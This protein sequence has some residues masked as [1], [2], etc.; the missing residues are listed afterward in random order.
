MFVSYFGFRSITILK[1]KVI[2]I[3]LS[4]IKIALSFLYFSTKKIR[5]I[6]PLFDIEKS[7]LFYVWTSI[8]NQAKYNQ[9]PRTSDRPNVRPNFYCANRPKWQ[10]F[11][12]QNTELFPILCFSFSEMASFGILIMACENLITFL[13]PKDPAP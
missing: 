5:K 6:W 11:F 10:N 4:M 3:C 7:E 9:I 12:L 2:K 13:I 1:V 8:P